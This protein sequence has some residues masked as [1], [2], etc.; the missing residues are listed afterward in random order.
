MSFESFPVPEDIVPDEEQK[1]VWAEVKQYFTE[2]LEAE[3]ENPL[4]D[5]DAQTR[6]QVVLEAI[7]E[8]DWSQAYMFLEREI[9]RLQLQYDLARGN[10]VAEKAGTPEL[11][12][13]E[14]EKLKELKDSLI[15]EE[16]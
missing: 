8:Q 13:G 7:E 5:D 9:D 14:I 12:L 1:R 2:A 4:S 16:K 6:L 3:E 10:E 11:I 15:L